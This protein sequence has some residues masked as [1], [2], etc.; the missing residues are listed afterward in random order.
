MRVKADVEGLKRSRSE[1]LA[2]AREQLAKHDATAR[3]AR[4]DVESA[5]R[6]LHQRQRQQDA[7]LKSG[8]RD[9]PV[10][11]SFEAEVRRARLDLERAAREFSQAK[12]R[13]KA[14]GRLVKMCEAGAAN[15][16]KNPA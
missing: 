5:W 13:Q 15:E 1:R 9:I 7:A 14:S 3:L 6:N 4:Q 8:L 12:K 16:A 11:V 10:L 2:G